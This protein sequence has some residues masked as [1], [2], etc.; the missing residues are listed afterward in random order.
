MGRGL[1]DYI[2]MYFR[3]DNRG[4]FWWKGLWGDIGGS[5]EDIGGDVVGVVGTGDP[6][7]LP[8]AW[9]P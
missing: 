1:R 7:P 9:H 8:C 4:R 5:W 3:K 6:S 2:M